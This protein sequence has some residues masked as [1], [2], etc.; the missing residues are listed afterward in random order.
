[1]PNDKTAEHP[2][3]LGITFAEEGHT[4][5][6][7][8]GIDY[9][10][11]TTLVKSAFAEFNAPAVAA[12]KS[13][14]TGVPAEQYVRE[15][16]ENR[17]RAA[18]EGT[19]MHENIE[20]QILGRLSD[21]HQPKDDAERTLFRAVWFE[22]EKIKAAFGHFGKTRTALEP[23]K[24]VFSPRFRVAGSIDLFVQ[25]KNGSYIIFDWKK[26]KEIKREAFGGRVGF[27]VATQG[28]PDCNF[29]HYALQ[30]S[31]YEQILK[32]EGYIPAVAQVERWLN[33]YCPEEGA[34][35]HVQ[36]PDLGREALILMA[37]NVT[38]DGMDDIP[39]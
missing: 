21:M 17:N 13:A 10:S 16:E 25:K 24:I 22:V 27:H 31:I 14:K 6:D 34:F 19:R 7:D 4:Y 18:T 1:M 26:V 20:R 28:L 3:G 33:V 23:E 8:Y 36:L 11:G 12:A 37:W 29:Y 35:D 5:V 30:L 2:R 32:C 38:N 15:W 39:F 9:T